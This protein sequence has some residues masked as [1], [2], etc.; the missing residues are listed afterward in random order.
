MAEEK[1]VEEAAAVKKA[2]E[3]QT[4]AEAKAKKAA[5]DKAA[6]DALTLSQTASADDFSQKDLKELTGDAIDVLKPEVVKQQ[7]AE[8][9]KQEKASLTADQTDSVKDQ[10]VEALKAANALMNAA[11]EEQASASANENDLISQANAALQSLG[12]RRAS[13]RLI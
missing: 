12:R 4:L 5:E 13:R 1:K 6:S 7:S 3:A 10:A 9:P 8:E 11:G 2:A